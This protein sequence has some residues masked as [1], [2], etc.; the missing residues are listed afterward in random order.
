M[1]DLVETMLLNML[2]G[3]GLDGLS[4]MVDDPTKPL[5]DVRRID[6]HDFVDESSYRAAPR[7][8]R[9]RV[10]TFVAIGCAT[11]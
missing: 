10:R 6:L 8:D 2:R 9:T 3:A 11:N 1:D 7:R 4:P 5:R